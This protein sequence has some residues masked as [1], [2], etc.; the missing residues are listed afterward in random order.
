M[1]S[2]YQ[3]SIGL[4]VHEKDNLNADNIVKAIAD[5]LKARLK[6]KIDAVEQISNELTK[7]IKDDRTREECKDGQIYNFFPSEVIIV[8]RISTEIKTITHSL[9]LIG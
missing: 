1:L 3:K 6:E 5:K 2:Y 8:E 9:Q 4:W 7:A